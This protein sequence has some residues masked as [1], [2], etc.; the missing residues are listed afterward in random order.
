MVSTA[1]SVNTGNQSQKVVFE[2]INPKGQF[3]IGENVNV[4][5][6]GNNIVRQVVIPNEAIT[7]VNGKPA[8][9]IKDKAEQYS[10]S[11]IVKGEN[12]DKST[13]IIKG[14]EDGERVVTANVYQM[15][16]MY[17]NQ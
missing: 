9:F 16:M 15:K 14:T 3:K 8:I 17:L 6:T 11:F 10:I 7:E 2:L 13:V 5:M 12:N 1:Q 4:R